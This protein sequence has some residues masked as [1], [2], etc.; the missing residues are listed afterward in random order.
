MVASGA[1]AQAQPGLFAENA[2]SRP[3]LA[4]IG[5]AVVYLSLRNG[6]SQPVRLLGGSTPVAERV[7]IHESV[8][9]GRVARMRARPGGV[10]VPP[11]GVIR[12]EPSGLHLMLIKPAADLKAGQGFTL[13][14]NFENGATFAVPVQVA[15][16]EPAAG[17]GAAH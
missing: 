11:G 12:F 13:T 9:E 5:T 16:R 2:W 8:V 1:S 17:H 10:V 7:E 14:L 6:G 3:A 15:M 4:R